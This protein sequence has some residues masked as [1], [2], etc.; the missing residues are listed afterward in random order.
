[1]LHGKKHRVSFYSSSHKSSRVLDYI[2]SN[3][4]GP[5]NVPLISRSVYFV[6][7]IDDYSRTFVYFLKSKSEGF[8]QFKEFKSLFENQT[9]RKIKCL[10][11]ENG[12][13]FCLEKN[14]RFCK[15]HGITR[16]KTTPYTPLQNRVVERMNKTL[17]ERARSM[18]SG[19]GLE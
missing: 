7:F 8:S 6:S 5:V 12:S 2:H 13:E 9:G 15:D 4:F 18:L 16:H 11:I 3:V 1:M 19:V 10:R 14:D 17:M